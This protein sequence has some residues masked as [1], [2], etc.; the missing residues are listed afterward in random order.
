MEN[1]IIMINIPTLRKSLTF[2]LLFLL[3]IT[4]SVAV[5][6][7][8]GIKAD[9]I[10]VKTERPSEKFRPV[11]Y[12]FE[13]SRDIPDSILAVMVEFPDLKFVADSTS[14]DG[15]PHNKLYYETYM[16]HMASYFHDA[17][18]G[19]Y[20]LTTE[21]YTVYDKVVLPKSHEFYGNYYED[22]GF[23]VEMMM[24][25]IVSELDDTIDFN[26]YDSFVIFHAGSGREADLYGSH[27]YAISSTFIDRYDLIDAYESSIEN[28]FSIPANLTEDGIMTDDGK[29]LHE[30]VLCPEGEVFDDFQDTDPILGMLGVLTHEFGH[31]LGMPTLFDNYS[32]NGRSAGIGYFG[33]MGNG[34]W[35][36]FGYV[37]PLPCAWTRYYMGWENVIEIDQFNTDLF[38]NH[39]S[40]TI[41]TTNKLYKINITD[42]E[43]FLIENR[44]QNP[45]SSRTNDGQPSFTF[46]LHPTDQKYYEE[47]HP[48]AGDPRF[49]FM[50]NTYQG[51]EWDFYLPGYGDP[52][53][54]KDGEPIDGSGLLIW[55]IDETIINM[56]FKDDF[57][58]SYVNGDASH[59]GVDLEEAD[60]IQNLDYYTPPSVYRQGSPLDAYRKGN[61]DY[62]GFA[63]HRDNPNLISAPT[64]EG[65]YG[66]T[67][68]EIYDISY[69]GNIMSFK[70]SNSWNKDVLDVDFPRISIFV[71]KDNGLFY[72]S[73]IFGVT[74][75]G[76]MEIIGNG[77]ENT[78]DLQT[79]SSV[80]SIRVIEKPLYNE[81]EQN[82]L[83]PV[84][85]N[86]AGADKFGIIVIKSVP[87]F[88]DIEIVEIRDAVTGVKMSQ[89]PMVHNL[90]GTAFRLC[91]PFDNNGNQELYFYDTDYN[92]LHS[93]GA[94]TGTLIGEIV[95]G[96]ANNFIVTL[97]NNKY[98][99]N[100]VSNTAYLDSYELEEVTF[101]DT[102][103]HCSGA[104]LIDNG[105]NIEEIV[106][107]TKS[108][109]MFIYNSNGEIEAQSSVDIPL[110][111]ISQPAIGNVSH[112]GKP[113]IVIGGE[114]SFAVY[115]AQGFLIS[116][117]EYSVDYPD[118]N[119]VA[120]PFILFDYYPEYRI[121]NTDG[122]NASVNPYYGL[123]IFGYTS[124]S[125]LGG[126]DF[127]NNYLTGYPVTASGKFNT[128]PL[129][130]F[131][132]NVDIDGENHH[133]VTY[134]YHDNGSKLT[135]TLL[136]TTE[137]DVHT[138]WVMEHGNSG[139]TSFCYN[140]STA[141]NYYTE[142]LFVPDEVYAFP[143][144]VTR[145]NSNEL[146]FNIMVN[147]DAEVQIKIFDIAAN[148]V[149]KRTVECNAYESNREKF[150]LDTS[151]L[152]SG[153]YIAVIKSGGEQ[154]TLKFAIEK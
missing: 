119:N 81:R 54:Y 65:N 87:D 3:T 116:Q 12:C 19:V 112:N 52:V 138:G 97:D 67:E 46:K 44:Q 66:S 103:L 82:I 80:S 75:E 147:K 133:I 51:C 105:N 27:P 76:Q 136:C 26:N 1:A 120:S 104:D 13:R 131:E 56:L 114:N 11:P 2:T 121:D 129:L 113:D 137:Q 18:H 150:I 22:D 72:P 47:G 35:N 142:S 100:V 125:R 38:I 122:G 20:S 84:T 117:P 144:P 135:R 111:T 33:I 42:T 5:P 143:N 32:A 88:T 73:Y 154:K 106:L 45:D 139:R 7:Y 146:K 69:S 53:I 14:F 43:Y 83:V 9:N 115:N 28:E 102:I 92:F 34:A 64:S 140:P 95:A 31:Q 15:V 89:H 58:Y 71:E 128:P 36:A 94:G 17:S 77:V 99:L 29:K 85:Y 23:R 123:D 10:E 39:V 90:F 21:N 41:N 126:W 57:E 108:K 63:T 152:S 118:T 30:F 110:N 25:D 55:H 24:A 70:A 149:A 6:V 50:I 62:F 48:H 134:F 124:L 132:E 37:P 4:I 16:K 145:I 141:N 68:I 86:M 151:K 101:E 8:P 78:Y 60:G 59:K 130:H 127:N 49:D 96:I 40:D 79:M 98:M 107:V 153:V 109:K 61:N 74:E 93:S 91:V 148:L